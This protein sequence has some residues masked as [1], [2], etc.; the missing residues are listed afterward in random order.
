MG[1]Q[2]GRQRTL[3]C[4][5]NKLLMWH[6]ARR[7]KQLSHSRLSTQTPKITAHPPTHPPVCAVSTT[8]SHSS[9]LS[10]SGQSTARTSSSSISAAVPGRLPSPVRMKQGWVEAGGW[11]MQAQKGPFRGSPVSQ[12]QRNAQQ[13]QQQ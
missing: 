2:V 12:Q 13:Q 3:L 6:R 7:R 11:R 1:R 10:L 5:P 8:S 9:V 4:S